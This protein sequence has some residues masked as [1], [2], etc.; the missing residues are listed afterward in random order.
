MAF[1]PDQDHFDVEDYEEVIKVGDGPAITKTR[2]M[3]MSEKRLARKQQRWEKDL[4][5]WEVA[6]ACNTRERR[7]E[8]CD[9]CYEVGW[10]RRLKCKAMRFEEKI[11][12]YFGECVM[13]CEVVVRSA[14]TWGWDESSEILKCR[15]GYDKIGDRSWVEKT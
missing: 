6:R 7:E 12:G 4:K 10:K 8:N 3:S 1:A 14:S 2:S 5:N 15:T 9:E 13:T 11:K